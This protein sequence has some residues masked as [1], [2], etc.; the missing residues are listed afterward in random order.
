[1]NEE[2]AVGLVSA[3]AM[4][5]VG[6]APNSVIWRRFAVPG[7]FGAIEPRRRPSLGRRIPEIS[8]VSRKEIFRK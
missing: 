1:M 5:R 6:P 7:A 2:V 8:A 4:A 3:A